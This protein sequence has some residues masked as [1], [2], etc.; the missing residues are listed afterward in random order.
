MKWTISKKLG[1]FCLMMIAVL[2]ILGAISYRNISKSIENTELVRHTF[3][4]IDENGD[5]PVYLW[6]A[7]SASRGLFLTGNQIYFQQYQES[8]K[9]LAKSVD[10]LKK[11]VRNEKARHVAEHMGDLIKNRLKA[12]DEVHHSYREGK[13]EGP[14]SY[15]KGGTPIRVSTEIV[16]VHNELDEL[17]RKLLKEHEKELETSNKNLQDLIL[18]GMPFALLLIGITGYLLTRSITLPLQGLTQVAEGISRGD[19]SQKPDGTDREDEIGI[20]TASFARMHDYLRSMSQVAQSLAHNDLTVHCTPISNQ[21]SLGNAFAAMITGLRTMGRELQDAAR[22]ISSSTTQIAAMSSQLAASSAETAAAVNETS[23]TVEEI[24]VTSQLVNQKSSFVSES[25]QDTAQLSFTGRKN[26]GET[27]NSMDKIRR[28]MDFIA[29]SIV[30][31]SEQSMAIGEI[32][33]SV[34]DLAGQSNLLAV[35]ASIEA[36]KAGEHGKGFAVVAQE[37]RSLAEQSKEATGQIRRILNDIQK[38]IS[39]AVMA[40]EQGGKTVEAGVRQ[41]VETEGAIQAIEQGAAG[42]VQAAAQILA[43][44]HEQVAGLNQVAQA[45][46]NI[47]NASDQIVLSTRQAEHSTSSLNEMGKKL[48]QLVERF[49]VS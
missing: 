42:T 22:L 32:I 40:T 30:K 19:L 9:N 1:G 27:M 49:K 16:K 14:I 35:N 24:K 46:D 44:T 21:D 15:I 29:E 48:W 41:T 5:I 28:Q 2:I 34:S 20:L 37:V 36:A 18:F 11:I 38:A 47:R 6:E 43:S 10:E 13:I 25:A 45:M 23:T 3:Q 39:S 31:L 17:E 26:I 33:T 7:E 12:F 4:I 8:V